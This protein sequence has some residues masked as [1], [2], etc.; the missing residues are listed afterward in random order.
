MLK[1]WSSNFLPRFCLQQITLK[2][3]HKELNPTFCGTVP[4]LYFCVSCPNS[5]LSFPKAVLRPQIATPAHFVVFLLSTRTHQLQQALQTPRY[6]L[7]QM[8]HFKHEFRRTNP[9]IWP[10]DSRV[11]TAGCCGACNSTGLC[12]HPPIVALI[13]RRSRSVLFTN[14]PGR[15]RRVTPSDVSLSFYW[16]NSNSSAAAELQTNPL[17]LRFSR[18]YSLRKTLRNLKY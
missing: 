6:Q 5:F 12:A 16:R 3:T 10:K 8:K 1:Y 7:R 11:L 9:V 17:V 13:P 4:P 18:H 15:T 2:Q 14:T